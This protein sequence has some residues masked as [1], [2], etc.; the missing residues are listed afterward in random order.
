MTEAFLRDSLAVERT[1]LANERT[2]LAYVR[3]SLALLACGAGIAQFLPEVSWVPATSVV[4]V[5][6]GAFTLG[7]GVYRFLKVRRRLAN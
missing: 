1:R 6:S 4:L 2:F 3:T 7:F 5:V